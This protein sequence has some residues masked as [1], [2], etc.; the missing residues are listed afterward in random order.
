MHVCMAIMYHTTKFRTANNILSLVPSLSLSYLPPSLFFP[1]FLLS[2]LATYLFLSLFLLRYVHPK[3]SL[4]V[5]LD[6]QLYQIDHK[7]YLLDFRCVNP[8]LDEKSQS[9]SSSA[10]AEDSAHSR[11]FVMEFFEICSRLISSLAQ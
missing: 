2:S 5:K 7:N 10:T 11:H 1:P 8:P 9:E 6:L 4:V 3:S